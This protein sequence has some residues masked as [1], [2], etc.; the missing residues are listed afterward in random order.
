MS[1]SRADLT[2]F[3]LGWKIA[4]VEKG[5]APRSL[6]DTYNEERLPVI[7][8]MLQG[9]VNISKRR[10]D[11]ARD[12]ATYKGPIQQPRHLKQFGINYRWSPIVMD[13]RHPEVANEEREIRPEQRQYG[14]GRRPCSR[15]HGPRA[16][17]RRE[18]GHPL[19]LALPFLSH[20]AHLWGGYKTRCIHY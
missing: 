11:N 2:L 17:Q 10:A 8:W 20:C 9:T 14:E 4:L 6:L 18:G 13:E 19:R 3:N 7:E 16:P 5:L 1:V 12:A 15:I